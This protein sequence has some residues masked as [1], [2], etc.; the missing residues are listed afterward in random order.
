ML[1][2]AGQKRFKLPPSM[3]EAHDA[4]PRQ[5]TRLIHHEVVKHRDYEKPK[6][7]RRQVGARHADAREVADPPRGSTNGISQ[8]ERRLRI[9]LLN[10]KQGIEQIL[11]RFGRKDCGLRQLAL[12]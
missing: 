7:L 2:K 9:V 5:A 10:P 1:D 4:R 11:A 8:I 6:S 3:E 12:R